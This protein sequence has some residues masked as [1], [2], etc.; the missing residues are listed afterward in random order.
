MTKLRQCELPI[1]ILSFL[2]TSSRS[3]PRRNGANRDYWFCIERKI[4]WN[5][6]IFT[7]C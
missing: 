6:N 5:T 1:F 7:I 4:A 2:P 3:I